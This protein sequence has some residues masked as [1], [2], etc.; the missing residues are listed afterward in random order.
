MT[1]TEPARPARSALDTAA[2]R[3]ATNPRVSV[4]IPTLNEAR[5]LRPVF[6]ALPAG[7][8]EVILVDGHSTDGTPAAARRLL[9]SVRVITQTRRGKGNA[10]A[11]G[12]AAVTGDIIVMI[13]ADGS[14]DPGE[15]PSF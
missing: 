6:G 15:I 11:C 5:T 13:D 10:L 12:F 2:D 1:V 14:T 4:V 8:H 7:L 9:P 3:P